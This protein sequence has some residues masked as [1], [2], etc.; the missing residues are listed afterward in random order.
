VEHDR[1]V[2]NLSSYGNTSAASIPIAFAEAV[3]EGK[4]K[5]GQTVSCSIGLLRSIS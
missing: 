2:S 3:H 4:I 1:V 5:P